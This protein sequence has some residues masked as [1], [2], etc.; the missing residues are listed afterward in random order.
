MK[1]T[2]NLFL[3]FILIFLHSCSLKNNKILS[4][5][6]EIIK[7]DTS[8]QDTN[9]DK[10]EIK[11]IFEKPKYIIG[12]PYSIE[13]IGYIPQENYNYQEIGLASFYGS[14]LHLTKTINNEYNK[15]T[16]L[17]ARHKTLPL[18]SVVKITNLEN[19]LSLIARVNDRG[20]L[21]NARIIEVSRKIAQLLRFY[22]SEIARVKVEILSDPSK[23]VK[24]VTQSMNDPN[25]ETTL[26]KAP[27]E[28]V[29]ITDLDELDTYDEEI[30]SNISVEQPI[31][32]GFEEIAQ[33]EIFVKV[34]GFNSYQDTENLKNLL[35]KRTTQKEKEGYSIIF[36][37]M[38][39]KD[40]DILFN[41]LISKGYKQTEIIIK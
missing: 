26:E 1:L 34:Q 6:K 30:N 3:L 19:G 32:L 12:N 39:N 27:T 17:Y 33:T 36:G 31:E 22:K 21:N 11:T 15:V 38:I 16:E 4:S 2:I 18:P 40:A 5:K 9:D 24:I 37:P 35:Y 14:D 28:G 8:N 7:T 23:Q 25:F 13:G 20:P 41:L 10:E 29:V